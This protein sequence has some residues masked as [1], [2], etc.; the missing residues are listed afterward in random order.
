MT[1]SVTVQKDKSYDQLATILRN[2]N[3]PK[4]LVIAER[5]RFHD[6]VQRDGETVTAF[7]ANL[8]SKRLASTC[9]FR[10]HLTEVLRD[11]LVCG[12][13]SKEIQKK[14]LTEEHSFDHALKTALSFE[15]AVKDVAEFRRHRPCSRVCMLSTRFLVRNLANHVQTSLQ[16]P[17]K[18]VYL[19]VNQAILDQ[20]VNTRTFLAILVG[21][22]GIWLPRARKES[23]K[24]TTSSKTR[25]RHPSPASRS[26]TSRCRYS[27][28]GAIKA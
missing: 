3:A 6:C 8:N 18:S 23:R 24:F 13:R 12:L 16:Q 7:A 22:P 19:V 25:P 20:S 28:S 26:T 27:T 1:T 9:N 17:P 21:K 4:K 11:R 10:S 14:L 5:Y 2:R 15:S